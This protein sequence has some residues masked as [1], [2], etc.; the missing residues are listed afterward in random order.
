MIHSVKREQ[1]SMGLMKLS[2]L[3]CK[4]VPDTSRVPPRWHP[5]FESVPTF[6]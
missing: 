6:L 4:F 1:Y 5:D 3:P 2:D